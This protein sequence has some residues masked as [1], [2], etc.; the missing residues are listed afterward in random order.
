MKE[1]LHA[2][3]VELEINMLAVNQC[4]FEFE[5]PHDHVRKYFQLLKE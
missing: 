4:E 3:A 2:E 1:S 5:L